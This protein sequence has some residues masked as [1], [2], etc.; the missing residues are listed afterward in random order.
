MSGKKI[1]V[2]NISELSKRFLETI[3][4]EQFGDNTD[5]VNNQNT[6]NLC[7]SCNGNNIAE[8]YGQG[9]MVCMDCGQVLDNILDFNPE[10]KQFED[11]DK[12][13]GRC[14][15]PINPLL[16]RSSLGTNISGMGKN[17]LKTLHGWNAMPYKERS[18][19][20]E[21]KKIH[22]VCQEAKIY[23]CIEDD[24]K[25][26]L[27]IANEC[28][29]ESGKNMGKYVIT[30]GKNRIS[31]SAA[32]IFFACIKNKMTRTS[33]EIASLYKI[34]DIEMNRGRKNLLKLLKQKKSK[35]QM[36]TSKPD[37]FIKRYCDELK[38]KSVYIDDAIKIAQNI[39][40]LNVASEH[41]PFSISAASILLMA[42][43]N[44]LKSITKK[45]LANEF[46]LSLA[47]LTKTYREIKKYKHIILN[48]ETIDKIVTKIKSD[49]QIDSV[50][51][52][53]LERMKKFG[54]INNDIKQSNDNTMELINKV[55]NMSLS[56]DILIL[57]KLHNNILNNISKVNHILNK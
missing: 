57:T 46:D 21:F 41:T 11:D 7:P 42:S 25:I 38:I 45:K 36:G 6:N 44:G 10:W 50:P 13:A 17:R 1:N 23:K 28:K 8:D 47:T 52:E 22:A 3:D 2:N 16:P 32:S 27:K 56:D 20:N 35:F 18:L 54:I 15:M 31:I 24:A 30:R 5:K 14:S 49:M 55:E 37:H 19:N 29:H 51:D 34:T 43:I 33:K 4:L 40:R 39:E 48:D 53:V 9:T 12:M 26:M